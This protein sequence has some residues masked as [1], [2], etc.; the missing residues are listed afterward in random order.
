MWHY[1]KNKMTKKFGT[2]EWSDYSVNCVSGCSHDCLY[3]Y[4][5]SMAIR[6]KRKSNDDWG[7]EEIRWKDVY[8][9]R[10]KLN[11]IIM[12]P[13]S[14]DITPSN[15]SACY[16]VLEKLVKAGNKVVVVSKPHLECITK[17][18]DGLND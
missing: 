5:K 12:F 15:L 1:R 14:H 9:K 3:C 4:A 2:K 8:K 7:D 10:K 17:I 13:T 16:E 18:C 11:G 6:F